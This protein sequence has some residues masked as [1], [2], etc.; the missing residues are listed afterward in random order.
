MRLRKIS[1]FSGKLDKKP[2]SGPQCTLLRYM[3]HDGLPITRSREDRVAGTLVDRGLLVRSETLGMVRYS[4]T[5]EGE[6]VAHG[7]MVP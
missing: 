1:Q 2:L 6:Q 7:L 4:L 5:P 3:V